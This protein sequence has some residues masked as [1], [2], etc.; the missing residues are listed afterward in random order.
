MNRPPVIRTE[1]LPFVRMGKGNE[2][3]VKPI[4]EELFGSDM[5][6]I[7][8]I[9]NS[10][11]Y[12]TIDFRNK[13]TGDCVEI[14]SR[15]C[16]KDTFKDTMVGFN[17]VQEYRK[18]ISEGKR[19]YFL[20]MFLD[21]SFLWEYTTANYEKNKQDERAIGKV[22]IRTAPPTYQK[23]LNTY[24][25]FNPDKTHLYI[26]VKNL[27]HISNNGAVIPPE[28]QEYFEEKERK[29]QAKRLEYISRYRRQND[30][31]YGKCLINLKELEL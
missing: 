18:L 26:V 31:I 19:C 25:P 22:D 6:I 21:G 29:F 8:S 16:N 23:P 7:T 27:Q 10:S 11:H 1:N 2:D 9:T 30:A 17:K 28:L 4:I 5:E 13:T 14:K 15:T 24:T 3:N 12:D 20:F